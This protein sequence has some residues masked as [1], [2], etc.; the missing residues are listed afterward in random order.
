MAPI[1]L[2]SVQAPDLEKTPEPDNAAPPEAS[3]PPDEPSAAMVLAGESPAPSNILRVSVPA[4]RPY[5]F[6]VPA[7]APRR[8][9]ASAAP[10][11]DEDAFA[12]LTALGPVPHER[13]AR[14]HALVLQSMSIWHVIRRSYVGWVLLVRD[15]DYAAASSAIDG[16]EEENRDWPPRPVRERP[17]HAASPVTPLLFLTLIAFFLVTGPAAADSHWFS[18]GTAVTREVL[19]SQPW[20]AVTALTLHADG[21]HVLGNAISGTVFA[22]AVHR[23]LGAGGSAL[24]IL[25]SGILGNLGNAL[26]HRSI[27]DPGHASIG[28]S[29]AVFGAIGL[30]AATQVVVNFG[31]RAEDRKAKTSRSWSDI[32]GPIVGGFA[33]LGALGAGGPTTDLGAHLFG[34]LS[35]VAIGAVAAWPQRRHSVSVEAGSQKLGHTVAIGSGAPSWWMQT[36]LGGVAAAIVVIAWQMALRH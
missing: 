13:K 4:T 1:E 20:R 17:R 32:A 14:D 23:R 34:F 33:L 19:S 12:G 36:A 21:T 9:R 24:A 22:S 30:L 28:A 3:P 18:Q 7:L 15:A 5:P 29:T 26:W 11:A 31:V 16:Y 2:S 10:P 25:A 8:D 27:G 6:A 35:G